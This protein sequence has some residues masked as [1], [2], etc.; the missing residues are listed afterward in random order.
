[1][2]RTPLRAAVLAAGLF[3]AAA[4]AAD[5]RT[6]SDTSGQFS[7]KAKYVSS[8]GGKVTL[9]QE[10]GTHLEI[11]LAKLSDADKKYV[12]DEQ[13][14]GANPFQKSPNN[15]FRQKGK[16]PAPK[17]ADVA[18]PP[19]TTVDASAARLVD[20][21]SD[22]WK[23][24]ASGTQPADLAARA[25]RLPAKANFF[26]KTAGLAVNESAKRAVVGYTLDQPRP[27]GVTRLVP[28]DLAS[29]QA[30]PAITVNGLF[31]PVALAADGER[32]LMRRAEFGHGNNDRLE[33]W[34][35]S[36]GSAT[37]LLR[38]VP[39]DAA[40]GPDRDVTW[41]AF[42]GDK[43]ATVSAGG[44]LVVWSLEPALKAEYT[45]P[46]LGQSV[47]AV[48]PDGTL[49]AFASD[50]ELGVLDAV[51]GKIVGSRALPKDH[52]PFATFAFSPNGKRIGCVAFDRLY[53]WDA[54]T[55]ELYRELPFQGVH[56][57]GQIAWT[58]PDHV[59]VGGRAL[60]DLEKQIRLWDYNGAEALQPAGG[61]CWFVAADG[62]R[63]PGALVG[64]KVPQDAVRDR[65]AKALTEPDF[66]VFKPGTAVAIDT[67]GLMDAGEA[68]RV[69]AAL[70][71][72]VQ[73]F[74]GTVSDH[75]TIALQAITDGGKEREV[76][77]HTFGSPGSR[78]YKVREFFSRVKF[79]YQGKTVWEW[80]SSSVPGFTHLKKDETMEEHLKKSEK[81]SYEFFDR[82]EL[83]K[84][85]TKPT[86]GAPG[87]GQSRVTTAGLR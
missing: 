33:L 81:P 39:Y 23:V 16:A 56:V 78:A 42:V 43:L 18:D 82:V 44:S 68:D 14:K 83:P 85:L 46:V 27:Q 31:A 52:M 24:P 19:L 72:K 38:F 74:G 34:S 35:L 59:L 11:E 28:V 40:K 64:A 17:P 87:L 79:V 20:L 63:A 51:V 70:T 32:V 55:G 3:V 80:S 36:G 53:V 71:K 10:D 12:A 67:T 7:V 77:Y 58:G 41:A 45:L 1:M 21:G 13:R 50:K 54:A 69:R 5:F 47:P 61:L 49:I 30:Q 22:A 8:A 65:L 25:I 60:L 2:N 66:F 26:E 48:S 75:G 73:A 84:L 6:W 37:K 29:G 9:E 57:A 86:G 76:F 62:D 15:P 4:V